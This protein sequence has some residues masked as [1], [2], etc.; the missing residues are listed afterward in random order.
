MTSFGRQSVGSTGINLQ[1]AADGLPEM[2]PGGVTLDW[3]TVAAVSGSDQTYPDGTVVKVGRKGLRLG[4]P[5]CKITATGKYGPY[6][7]AAS[8]GR[9]ILKRGDCYI[10]NES[11]LEAPL[12]GI[13]TGQNAHP[14]VLEGGLVWKARLLA[15]TGTHSL[16]AGPTFTELEAVFPRLRYAQS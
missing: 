12:F 8:D 9:E 13:A 11:W 4:Q 1:V 14:P 5:L 2:K 3:S 16:A 6:D 15:T 7:P 10:L